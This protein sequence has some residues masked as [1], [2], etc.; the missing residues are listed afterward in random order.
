METPESDKKV[1]EGVLTVPAVG[2]F[3]LLLWRLVEEEAQL[4]RLR[5]I[6]PITRGVK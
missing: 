4:L 1:V 3:V 6:I 2:K 5:T